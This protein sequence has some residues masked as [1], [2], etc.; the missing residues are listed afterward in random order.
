MKSA[1]DEVSICAISGP[2]GTYNS[3]DPS[4]EK[5][6]AAKLGLK[7]ENVSTQV[8]PRDRHAMFFLTLGIVASSVER[9]STEIRH[10]QR[11]E[12]LEVEEYFEKN[13]KG[14]SAMPHKRNP[15]LS[16]NLTGIS[17]YIRSS[18]IPVSYTHLRAHET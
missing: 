8:I 2:V 11:T 6:V 12:L 14:S 4:I 1:K 16:E 15:I 5:Y 18:V 3:I 10:L 13:Q 17:R 9:L 7:N